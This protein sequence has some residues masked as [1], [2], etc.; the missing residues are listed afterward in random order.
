M[1]KPLTDEDLLERTA[2]DGRVAFALAAF[3]V[4]AGLVALLDRLGVPERLVAVLAPVATATGLATVGLL[5]RS[6]RISRFYAAGRAVPGYYAGLAL[7]ALGAGLFLPFAPPVPAGTTV[8]GLLAGFGIGFLLAAFIVGPFLRKTG[9]FSIPDLIASRFPNLALRLGVVAVVGAVGLLVGLAGYETAVRALLQTSGANRTSATVLTGLVLI[10]IIV[11]GGLAGVVWTATGAA[12][13]FVAA[14]ALPLILLAS[15]GTP[16]PIPV[17]GDDVLWRQALARMSEWQAIANSPGDPMGYALVAAIAIGVAVLAP[18]LSPAMTCRDG[19]S[20]R[21]AGLA[22]TAWIVVLGGL[23]AATMALTS[24]SFDQRMTGQRPDRLPEF[25]YTASQKGLVSICGDHVAGPAAAVEACRK[26]SGFSNVLRAEDFAASGAWLT[27]GLPASRG[28]SVAF[29]GLVG[30]ALTSIA[31]M[32]AAAGFQIV[33]TA[34]GHDAFYRVRDSSAL[35]SRRLAITRF[36]LIAGVVAS[37]ALVQS[38]ELDPRALIGLAIAFSTATLA[39]LLVLS[40]WPRA[41]GADA[42]IALLVGLA[43]AEIVIVLGG[44]SPTLERM[45]ASALIACMAGFAAGF[46]TSLFRAGGPESQGGAFVHGVLHGDQDVL[47]PDKGA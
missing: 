1:K 43:T 20:S 37:G 33:G 34:I 35:T 9:A 44:G 26:T 12:G 6:M 29:S 31:M 40:L 11:P 8:R 22:A 30:A 25:V 47:N 41:A 4:G 32:I 3:A 36:V 17:F 2:I 27:I 14:F 5:V 28:L 38:V 15:R 10:L 16:L 39:P 42:T 18:L 23:V 19:G 13:I 21:L 45:A 24:M 7:A 46:A